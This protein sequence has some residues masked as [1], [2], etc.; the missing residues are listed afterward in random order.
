M[1]PMLLAAL[2][3]VARSQHSEHSCLLQKTTPGGASLLAQQVASVP[4]WT[5]AGQGSCA[6]TLATKSNEPIFAQCG[7]F[8][9]GVNG[10]NAFAV[11][12]FGVVSLAP[13]CRCCDGLDGGTATTYTRDA[14]EVQSKL[15]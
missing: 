13:D 5:A 12:F 15:W 4:G 9:D 10:A 6:V 11:G 7:Q 3:V 14:G 2:V 8:C 1:V